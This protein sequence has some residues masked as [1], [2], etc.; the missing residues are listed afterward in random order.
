MILIVRMRRANL[1]LGIAFY[2]R[3]G[4]EVFED[5]SPAAF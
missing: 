2:A 5:V 4:L 3:T 1:D